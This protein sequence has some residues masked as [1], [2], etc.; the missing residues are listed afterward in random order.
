MSVADS[1]VGIPDVSLVPKAAKD[2]RFQRPYPMA[3]SAQT[4]TSRRLRSTPSDPRMAC[5]PVESSLGSEADEAL[6]SG[7]DPSFEMASPWSP[8]PARIPAWATGP[9][10]RQR[11]VPLVQGNLIWRSAIETSQ[12]RPRTDRLG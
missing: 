5:P 8:Q 9:C 4:P 7:V 6:L 10:W 1:G 12:C 3:T 2:V 11:S